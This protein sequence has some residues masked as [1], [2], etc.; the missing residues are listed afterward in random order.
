M[1]LQYNI[2]QKYQM[3]CQLYGLWLAVAEDQLA[4]LG[5][6]LPFRQGINPLLYE[7]FKVYFLLHFHR[8]LLAPD[9]DQL[10]R[11]GSVVLSEQE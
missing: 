11:P 7:L 9:Q 8:L 1:I 10:A 4:R 6:V 2:H 3:S 5:S